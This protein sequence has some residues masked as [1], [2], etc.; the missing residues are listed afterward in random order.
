[1]L[2]QKAVIILGALIF[3]VSSQAEVKIGYMDMQKAIQ[4]TSAGKN[5]KKQ[6]EKEFDKKKKEFKKGEKDLKKMTKDLEKKR[7][8]LSDKAFAQKQRGLQEKMFKY[9]QKLRKSQ[10]EIQAKERK[11][12]APILK[13]LQK[14]INDVAKEE[15]LSMVFEKSE[16]SVLW[17]KKEMDITDK[18][19]KKFE[20]SK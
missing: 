2:K 16:Q 9:Q 15:K 18:V 17:A 8:A 1:M 19:V 10:M 13:K 6:L 3:S 5:A 20:K 11:L 4:A 7:L 14:V 12:T